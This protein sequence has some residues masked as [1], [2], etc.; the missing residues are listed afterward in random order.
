[1]M[2]VATQLQQTIASIQ[3]AAANLK[4]FALQTQDQQ[5][6]T[7]FQQ[8]AE[9]MENAVQAL[10]QRQQYNEGQEPQYRQS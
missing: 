1:M 10:Q 2:T 9:D 8:L 4:S 5:A 3:G 6:K 7:Q